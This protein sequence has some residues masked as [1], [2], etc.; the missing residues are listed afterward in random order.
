VYNIKEVGI[1][2]GDFLLEEQLGGLLVCRHTVKNEQD[3]Q[4]ERVVLRRKLYLLHERSGEV[5]VEAKSGPQRLEDKALRKR[6]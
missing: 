1:P 4:V 6:Q 5:L 3:P 2:A